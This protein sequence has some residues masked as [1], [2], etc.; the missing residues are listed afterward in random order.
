M[1]R[2]TVE[3]T[4]LG[5]QSVFTL[6]MA[7]VYYAL[8]F[9]QRRPY[10]ATWAAGWA[11]YAVRLH[12]IM[13]FIVTRAEV[14]LFAHQAVTG[15][16]AL[17]LLLAALQFSRG[18]RFKRRYLALG[19]VAVAWAWV[20]IFVI[21]NMKVAGISSVVL[22][23]A[24]TLWT[25]VVFFRHRAKQSSR[26][27]LLLAWTFTL[28]GVHHLDYP[29]LRPLGAGVLYGVF[30]DVL[31]IMAS[32]V[33][34]MFLVLG[35]GR[36]ALQARTAQLEQLTRLVLRA[37]EDERRRIARALHDEAGQ[38]LTAVKI[39]L[40]LDGR[41]EASAMVGRALAQVRDLSN[42]L[43]PTVLDDL[44]L[45]PALRGLVEDFGKATR[46][47]ARLSCPDALPPLAADVEVAVYRVVQ[48][49]LTN[50]ARHARASRADV[51]IAAADG[52][53]RVTV[54]DDGLGIAGEPEPHLGLLGMRERVTEL[55]G[56]LRVGNQPGAGARIEATLPARA[57]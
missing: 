6:L 23:S 38:V 25:G 36:R 39:E 31:F 21:H 7:G 15:V 8:W 50:V 14:W 30:A 35:E 29:I 4:A 33:G 17:L 42:L 9:R 20:S 51:A 10:F 56:R 55:G 1:D 41:T 3:L 40:D 57:A 5:F 24:V 27:A 54:V 22:L 44:G 2:L 48:E 11:L 49:A 13:V 52:E 12:F 53:V 47:Q 43:R 26:G 32:A 37:Q 28:W 34:T 19:V 45:L 46:I 18:V 16:S